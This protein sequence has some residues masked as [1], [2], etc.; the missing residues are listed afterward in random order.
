MKYSK[1][2][3]GYF[4]RLDHA[5]QGEL[6]YDY[7]VSAIVGMQASQ[8]ALQLFLTIPD[9]V[10]AIAHYKVTGMPAVYAAAEYICG[11]LEGR[12]VSNIKEALCQ[13]AILGALELDQRYIH[14]ASL[15]YHVVMQCL[16]SHI[17]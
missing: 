10:V 11:W 6:S 15:V 12:S 13:D 7:N 8:D 1:L 14:I 9:D 17:K 3:L 4:N 5:V 16:K 2:F